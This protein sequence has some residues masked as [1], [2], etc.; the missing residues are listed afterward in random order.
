MTPA[1]PARPLSRN[2]EFGA[3]W[4]GQT[5]SEFGTSLS[6]F[7]Y[8]LLVLALTG[9]AFQAGLVGTV[10]ASTTFVLR[11]PAGAW[12]DRLDRRRL[13]LASDAGRALALV[14]IPIADLLGGLT[15]GHILAVAVVEGA[16]GVVFGPAEAAAVRRVV[17]ADQVRDAVARNQIRA[18]VAGLLGPIAGGALFTLGRAVPFA[19]DAL[20]YALSFVWVRTI[21]TP[22]RA[23]AEDAG[24][25]RLAAEIREGLSC[26]WRDGFLRAA[27]LWLAGIGVAFSSIGLVI[28]VLA[29]ESGAGAGQLGVMSALTA[30]GGFVGALLAPWLQA[31]CRPGV[32]LVAF[33]WL[34]AAVAALI[35]VFRSPYALGVL[36]AAAFLLFPAVNA[37]VFGHLAAT[38]PDRLQGRANAAVRQVTMMLMPVG[39]VVAGLLIDTGGPVTTAAIYAAALTTLAVTATATKAI[40]AFAT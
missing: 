34:A 3:L 5:I 21:R 22:L 35:V 11:L 26:W 1:A 9:S 19:C 23:D 29:L 17:A 6:A 10:L 28:L 39:P 16:L 13:M 33:G 38:V 18:Q 37:V 12:A 24:R 25:R 8:P 27:A 32:L 40:R 15:V 2:R 7:A 30:S 4:V 14:S 36:G 31:R 20:S